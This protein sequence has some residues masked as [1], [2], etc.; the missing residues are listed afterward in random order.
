MRENCNGMEKFQIEY[1]ILKD[2]NINGL[3][4][5]LQIIIVRTFSLLL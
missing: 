4:V 2:G 5:Q 3:D 1:S